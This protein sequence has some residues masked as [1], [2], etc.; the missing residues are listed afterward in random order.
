MTDLEDLSLDWL[1]Q[2]KL[3]GASA[4]IR[5]LCLRRYKSQTHNLSQLPAYSQLTTLGL[6]QSNL[7]SLAGVERFANLTNG[8][9]AY[10]TKL[11][12][13]KPLA[14]TS[15]HELTFEACKKIKDLAALS[16]CPKL[17]ILRYAN[18]ADLES[19]SFLNSF[20]SLQEF[21]F[22]KV[23]IKDGDMSLF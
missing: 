6:V 9:F 19:L 17:E 2:F 4:P 10:M 11:E 7:T 15:V 20:H 13:V 18:C 5:K 12:I 23:T 22:V 14:Q 16:Q 8:N 3:P 1:P 21:R